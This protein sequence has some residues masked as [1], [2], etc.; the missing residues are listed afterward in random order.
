MP[1]AF[2]QDRVCVGGDPMAACVRTSLVLRARTRLETYLRCQA[3]FGW[4]RL[5]WLAASTKAPFRS[6]EPKGGAVRFYIELGAYEGPE[7]VASHRHLRDVLRIKDTS[8]T[9]D[10]EFATYDYLHWQFALPDD[11]KATGAQKD[12]HDCG[13]NEIVNVVHKT[14]I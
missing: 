3:R 14:V 10:C 8:W 13:N 1:M 4:G 2:L 7:F 6:Q 9:V 11:L 12:E 5:L